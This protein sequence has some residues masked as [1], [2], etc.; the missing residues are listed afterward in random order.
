MKKIYIQPSI[1]VGSMNTTEMIAGAASWKVTTGSW[2]DSSF[3]G[4][5]IPTKPEEGD[6]SDVAVKHRGFYSSYGDAGW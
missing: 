1:S 5:Y 4:T 3:S 2:D 6:G